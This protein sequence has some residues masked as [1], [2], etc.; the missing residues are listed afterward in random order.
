LS[1]CD[2]ALKNKGELKVRSPFE[3]LNSTVTYD[4]P[5][6]WSGLSVSGTTAL[7]KN[8]QFI[9]GA[10]SLNIASNASFSLHGCH[11][12]NAQTG[13]YTTQAPDEFYGNSFTSCTLG[14]YLFCDTTLIERNLFHGCTKGLEFHSSVKTTPLQLNYNVF[15]S[16]TLG[17]EVHDA[18]LRIE[19]NEWSY[20]TTG[21]RQY[22]GAVHM[23]NN[24]GNTYQSN[25]I[26]VKFTQLSLL[27]LDQ[28]HNQWLGSSSLDIEGTFSSGNN[29][30]HNGSYYYLSAD[31]TLFTSNSSTDLH[32]GRD[33][34]Y[35]MIGSN[36]QTSSFLCPSKGPRKV[37]AS[38]GRSKGHSLVVYP[39]PTTSSTVVAEFDAIQLWGEIEIYTSQGL[40]LDSVGLDKGQTTKSLQLPNTRGTYIVRLLTPNETETTRVVL[41]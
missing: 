31:N 15:S 39:N 28:G 5:K 37:A 36:S 38:L 40:L 8:S 30:S 34:V 16:N 3:L 33:K 6:Q 14:A 21:H 12:S 19:C 29:L 32:Y 23:G 25:S 41:L 11:F 4:G 27:K 2:I 35:P 26:G 20:N 10:P 1:N 22:G 17:S 9:G 7:I 13:I 18:S 24:A